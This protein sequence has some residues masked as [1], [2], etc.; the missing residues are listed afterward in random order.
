MTKRRKGK[1]KTLG[2]EIAELNLKVIQIDSDIKTLWGKMDITLLEVLKP[3]GTQG[4]NHCC[5]F[6][7]YQSLGAGGAGI[8]HY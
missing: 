7:P 8:G 4:C 6:K 5:N 2:Q 1:K 3:F